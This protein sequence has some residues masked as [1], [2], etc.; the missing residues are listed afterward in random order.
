[1]LNAIIV[2]L[3]E[4]WDFIIVIFMWGVSMV[5]VF[6]LAAKIYKIVKLKFEAFDAVGLF[7]GVLWVLV[8]LFFGFNHIIVYLQDLF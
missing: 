3:A 6:V 7:F 2:W 8:I 1:M 4:N 5:M